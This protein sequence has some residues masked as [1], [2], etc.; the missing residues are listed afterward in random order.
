VRCNGTDEKCEL[1]GGLGHH[2]I[3][4]CPQQQIGEDVRAFLKMYNMADKG[5]MPIDGGALNQTQ[6][7]VDAMKYLDWYEDDIRASDLRD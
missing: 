6:S 2:K 1:C 3:T 7:F 5:I 4:S